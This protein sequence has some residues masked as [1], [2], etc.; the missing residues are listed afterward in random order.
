MRAHTIATASR[1]RGMAR[2]FVVALALAVSALAV[3]VSASASPAD[4][5]VDGLGPRSTSRAGRAIPA[6]P[7][8]GSEYSL[9]SS[10]TPPAGEQGPP[11]G[12]G[13]SALN[14]QPT[15]ASDS[16]PATADGFD[17]SSAAVGAGAV[18]AVLAL[19]AAALLTARSG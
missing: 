6:S 18:L 19:G 11:S 15:F 10:I 4:A 14:G 3:L 8:A 5:P 17:W 9:V 16:P 7:P 1:P 13:D 12:S 2:H